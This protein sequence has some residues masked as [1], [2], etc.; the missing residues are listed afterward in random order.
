VNAA[1]A[2]E[3]AVAAR[4]YGGN[5][6]V[7]AT[8]VSSVAAFKAALVKA[9]AVAGPVD[10]LVNNAGVAGK[11]FAFEDIDEDDFDRLFAVHVK[12]GFFAAQA[13]VG[14]MKARSY[15]RIVNISSTFGIAGGRGMSHYGGAKAALLAFTKTWARELAAFRITVN[16]VAPG[17]VV[18]GM[19]RDTW[20]PDKRPER[21][22]PI[23]LNR[24]GEPVEISYAV[25]WLASDEAA[26]VTGQVLSPNGGEYIV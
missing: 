13:V 24:P 8:D 25:A 26:W 22:K 5:I 2:E 12:G 20:P 1:A 9:E 3:T 10:I 4:R 21:L 23:P 15:G 19:T 11:G 7:V 17:F 18:T 16:A 6:A 14:G